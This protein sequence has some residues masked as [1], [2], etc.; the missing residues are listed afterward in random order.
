MDNGCYQIG[1]LA[2]KYVAVSME[3]HLMYW[4]KRIA[5]SR[6]RTVNYLS[7]MESSGTEL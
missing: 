7:G 3:R 5:K 2:E 6:T 1:E 4:V